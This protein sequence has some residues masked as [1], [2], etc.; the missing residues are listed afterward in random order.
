[1]LVSARVE[2]RREAGKGVGEARGLVPLLARSHAFGTIPH[3][4]V[5]T[6][7]YR[8]LQSGKWGNTGCAGPCSRSSAEI[9]Q[10]SEFSAF[11]NLHSTLDLCLCLCPSHQ[12]DLEGGQVVSEAQRQVSHYPDY[13]SHQTALLLQPR[14][15]Q[16]EKQMPRANCIVHSQGTRTT[17]QATTTAPPRAWAGG[18]DVLRR[19]Q[20]WY[21][22]ASR[23][24][25]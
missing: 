4:T 22:S 24:P 16:L 17:L 14:S 10:P 1:M 12:K 18:L 3:S 19:I 11:C 15:M 21:Q 7:A 13:Q 2:K 6:R 23:H 20:K 9:A 25:S 5:H 8:D